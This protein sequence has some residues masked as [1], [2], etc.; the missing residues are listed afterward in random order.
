MQIAQVCEASRLSLHAPATVA[1]TASMKIGAPAI[2][3][4]TCAHAESAAAPAWQ[5]KS[6]RNKRVKGRAHSSRKDD[7]RTRT[8]A[9]RTPHPQHNALSSA[10][11]EPPPP[12][13]SPDKVNHALADQQKNSGKP[14]A[15]TCF[16]CSKGGHVASACKSNARLASKCYACDG[17]GHMARDYATRA[18]QAKAQS[19]STTSNAVASAGKGAA[20]V[21]ASSAIAEVRIHDALIDTGS[22]F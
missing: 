3:K 13:A 6:S 12:Y 1:A 10:L 7:Q 5:P 2:A 8:S 4:C 17:I 22:A 19:S 15:I 11:R 20:Q 14:C 9:P 18:T 21:F 16:K